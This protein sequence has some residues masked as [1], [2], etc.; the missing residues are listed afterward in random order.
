MLVSVSP[1]LQ[2]EVPGEEHPSLKLSSLDEVL[3]AEKKADDAAKARN[4][5]SASQ[6]WSMED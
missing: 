6:L 2:D 3:E 5:P 1:S 4:L